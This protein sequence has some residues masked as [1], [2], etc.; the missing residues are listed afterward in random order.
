V[1]ALE[2]PMSV[3]RCG[4]PRRDVAG[5]RCGAPPLAGC[6]SEAAR[7]SF[8]P[9]TIP[10]VRKASV[11]TGHR[12]RTF[13]QARALSSAALCCDKRLVRLTTWTRSYQMRARCRGHTLG[14]RSDR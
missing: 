14:H 1:V 3:S 10:S 11:A 4:R 2:G 9:G 13:T 12:G 6:S 8:A 5:C 7:A